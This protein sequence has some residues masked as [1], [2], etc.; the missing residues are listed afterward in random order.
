MSG[1]TKT[2]ALKQPYKLRRT[3]IKYR[4]LRI[5][6]VWIEIT[7]VAKR[8]PRVACHVR[9]RR[10]HGLAVSPPIAARRTAKD[11][12]EKITEYR[13]RAPWVTAGYPRVVATPGK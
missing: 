2:G 3:T 7:V 8:W 13:T 9:L 5:P 10:N 6:D 4:P 11:I 12:V 1:V